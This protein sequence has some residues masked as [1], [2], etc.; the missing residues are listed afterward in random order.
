MWANVLN[1]LPK[2]L[3]AKAKS[4]GQASADI[5]APDR[6][7][8]GIRVNIDPGLVEHVAATDVDQKHG[9]SASL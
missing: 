3:Q 9:R 8:G 1:K 4:E 6:G 2:H 7:V 5:P